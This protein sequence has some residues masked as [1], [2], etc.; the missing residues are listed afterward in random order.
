MSDVTVYSK[1]NCRA[2]VGTKRKL[3]KAGVNYDVVD[4]TQDDEAFAFIQSEGVKAMPYVKTPNGSW[5]GL[6]EA[7]IDE[8]VDSYK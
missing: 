7:K 8:L 1:P 4:V 6:D 3:D 2:C 5:S